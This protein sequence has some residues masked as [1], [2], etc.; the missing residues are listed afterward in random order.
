MA[1]VLRGGLT[2]ERMARKKVMVSQ[3]LGLA[4]PVQDYEPQARLKAALDGLGVPTSS[5]VSCPLPG[6]SRHDRSL[7]DR[8]A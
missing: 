5:R 2:T 8:V 6:L 3:D 1:P 4:L 7:A